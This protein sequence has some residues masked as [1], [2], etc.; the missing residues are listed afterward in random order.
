MLESSKSGK[1][2]SLRKVRWVAVPGGAAGAGR[3]PVPRA[4]PSTARCRRRRRVGELL[5]DALQ[6]PLRCQ[7]DCSRPR[8]HG[9][10]CKHQLQIASPNRYYE[11][12]SHER[13]GLAGRRRHLCDSMFTATASRAR[14]TAC[15]GLSGCSTYQPAAHSLLPP[16]APCLSPPGTA[17]PSAAAALANLQVLWKT[18]G[19]ELMLAGFF[20][21]MWTVFVIM[22][23]EGRMAQHQPAM[24]HPAAAHAWPQVVAHRQQHAHFQEAQRLLAVDS[25]LRSMHAC[26]PAA[27]CLRKIP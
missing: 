15:P 2:P 23:G 18:Y 27:A 26:S 25:E 11:K 4:P 6:L 8:S 19:K 10:A 21:L 20:K 14:T 7:S 24:L 5:N 13:R 9:A 17:L 16:C 3:G 22:G 12:R 1:K